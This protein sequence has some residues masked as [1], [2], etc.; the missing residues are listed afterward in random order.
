MSIILGA[1][2]GFLGFVP[3]LFSFRLAR[4]HPSTGT[5]SLGLYGLGGVFVSLILLAVGLI[6]CAV[7][8][9]SE[10]VA[11]AIPEA[12]VFLGATIV[13]VIR[14]NAVFKR[15]KNQEQTLTKGD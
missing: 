10:V 14:R 7:V 3:L 2:V 15:E 4:K 5:L 1:L 13:F 11:F 8:A 9:R 6:V 12:V